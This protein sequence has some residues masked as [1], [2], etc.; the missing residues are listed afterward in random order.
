MLH[1]VPRI[2]LPR[3]DSVTRAGR[4]RRGM[5]M[6]GAT[7]SRPCAPSS[8]TRKLAGNLGEGSG[9]APEGEPAGWSQ[10]TRPILVRF[11]SSSS[12]RYGRR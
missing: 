3:G 12:Y 1:P 7:N 4:L 11:T 10:N 8:L 9:C 5:L 2:G 6:L